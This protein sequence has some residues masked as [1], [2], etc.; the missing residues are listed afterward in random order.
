[1]R[2]CAILRPSAERRNALKKIVEEAGVAD[3][4]DQNALIAKI[5]HAAKLC[6]ADLRAHAQPA[7]STVEK[8]FLKI[9]K[10]AGRLLQ[11]LNLQIVD[12]PDDG[13][14][15]DPDDGM[16]PGPTRERLEYLL[17]GHDGP[18][19]ERGLRHLVASVGQLRGIA[20]VGRLAAAKEKGKVKYK[21]DEELNDFLA[22]SLVGLKDV[23]LEK[24]VSRHWKTHKAFGRILRFFKAVFEWMD[25]HHIQSDSDLADYAAFRDVT[26]ES[27]AMRINRQRNR[28]GKSDS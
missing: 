16:P 6:L 23:G 8:N 18:K 25:L 26:D 22:N 4:P 5:E 13:V 24:G 11:A 20:R 2:R 19:G 3:A 1:M 10:R 15:D 12:D 27:L 14:E 28:I 7:P 17:G 21:G 9:E